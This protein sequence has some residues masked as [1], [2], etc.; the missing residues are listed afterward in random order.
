[1]NGP[2]P[3]PLSDAEVKQLQA[4]QALFDPAASLK[5]I[6]DFSKW[7]FA[8]ISVIGTLGAAFSNSALSSLAPC[9]K[10]MFAIAV[11]LT[12]VSLF[13]ATL[14]IE[15]TWVHANPA[16][17]EA[18][19]AAVDANIRARRTPLRIAAT[20]FAIAI[21]TAALSPLVSL[22]C[23]TPGKVAIGYEIK[24]DGKISGQ[25]TASKM[26]AFIPVELSIQATSV[27]P[28]AVIPRQRKITDEK[29]QASLSIDLPVGK[30]SNDLTLVV[31]WADRNSQGQ[32]LNSSSAALPSPNAN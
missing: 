21:I 28:N 20:L 11:L 15:P 3:R 19:L 31:K 4:L 30:F 10:T 26:D 18:M 22:L 5:R 2:L 29:G 24:A 6:D 13:A 27:P 17:R 7:I 9:G 16:S 8:S 32:M 14:A 1:M 23:S 25:A 12:G